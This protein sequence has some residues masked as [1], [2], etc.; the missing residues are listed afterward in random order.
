MGIFDGTLICTDLDGTLYRNDKSVSA[1]NLRAIEFFKSEG[2]YFT[3]ITGRMPYYAGKAL[4]VICPNAPFGCINGGGVFDHINGDYVWRVEL[5]REALELVTYIDEN[6]PKVGIQISTLY[7]TYF[8]KDNDAMLQFREFTG[9]PNLR[10]H[11]RDVSEAMGKILFSTFDEEEIKG[12]ARALSQHPLAEKFSFIRSQKS[13]FEILPGGISKGCALTKLTEYL[14]DKV[15]C[16]V[17]V[18]D[19][20]NDVSMLKS[21]DIGVAVSN[22]CPEALAAADVVT[23]S[24]EQD[25]LARIIYDIRDGKIKKK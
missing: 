22:A 15:N 1:E 19:Y 7:K 8:Y 16:T 12:V 5:P 13:L 3:F 2:G 20:Y 9:L 6:F 25:A 4:G 17:A 14:G 21:A 11:Y 10:S 24:N 23:V 18:G